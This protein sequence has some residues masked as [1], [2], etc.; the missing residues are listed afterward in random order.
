MGEKNKYRVFGK[1]SYDPSTQK[2]TNP[3]CSESVPSPRSDYASTIIQNKVWTFEGTDQ[4]QRRLC[5]LFQLNIHSHIWTQ[6]ESGQVK[7][8]CRDCYSLTAI[9]ETELILVNLG[10][11][12]SGH[13]SDAWIM[14]L[15]SI[16]HMEAVSIT[17]GS[18]S[19]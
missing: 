6:I 17:T 19:L 9:S 18:S 5:D 15:L 12:D 11:E 10:W 1:T 16:T 2:W 7:P 13:R 3:E 14:G 8:D 4:N